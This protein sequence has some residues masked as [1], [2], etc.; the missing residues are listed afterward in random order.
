MNSYIISKSLKQDHLLKINIPST[1]FFML[2]Y[3]HIMVSCVPIIS[4][5]HKCYTKCFIFESHFLNAAHLLETIG[6]YFLL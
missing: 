3:I 2:F 6:Q 1:V 5:S 4:L